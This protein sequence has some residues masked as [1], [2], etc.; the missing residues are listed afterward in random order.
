MIKKIFKYSSYILFAYAIFILSKPI[1][2]YAKEFIIQN[3]LEYE[4][5]QTIKNKKVNPN[6]E[7]IYPIA[8]ININRINLNSIITGGNLEKALEVSIAHI[9]HTSKPGESGNICLAGHRD[10]FFKKLENIK[11]NDIIEIKS[12]VGNNQYKVQD[13]KIIKPDETNYLYKSNEDKLTLV[14]CYPFEY[15][16]NAPLRYIVIAKP[17]NT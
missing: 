17:F 15:L 1:L 5:K 16:G 11:I 8:K 6:N 14:T 10:T 7:L 13:I 4:W 9:P 12:L 2:F 3:K